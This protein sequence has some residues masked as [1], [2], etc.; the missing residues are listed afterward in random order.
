MQESAALRTFQGTQGDP[1]KLALDFKILF[2]KQAKAKV[3]VGNGALGGRL[4]RTA[5]V[6]A[7]KVLLRNRGRQSW[8]F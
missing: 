1:G 4:V 8:K 6:C 3:W 2:S 5:V 7:G